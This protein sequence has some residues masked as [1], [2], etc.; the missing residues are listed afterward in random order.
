M[1]VITKICRV[2]GKP[3]VIDEADQAFYEKVG[4]PLPTLCPEER[5]RRRFAHR[6]ERSLYHRKCDLSGKSII[7][8]FAPDSGFTVYENSEWW[9]D[10]W[11][12]KSY[13]RDFDF[14]RPFFDQFDELSKQVPELAMGVW[15]SENSN[16]CNYVGNVKDSYLIFGSVYS[17]ACY[18][19][20]PYYSLNCVDTLVVR[21]C[22]Y[23]YECVD[24]RKLY[25][26][27]YCQDC[28]SSDSL[29][30]CY[31]LQGCSEC[32]GCAGLRNKKFCVFNEQ[33]S[34]EDYKKMKTDLNLCDPKVQKNLR[35][36]LAALKIQIPHRY[37]Q[38][39]QA[40]NASGNYIF[41]SKNAKNCYFT[42]R[43]EDTAYT[44]QVVDLKDCSD[45]NYTEENEL[46][47]E[48]LGSYQN[49]KL[50]FSKFCNKVSEGFYCHSCFTS[51][52]LFGCSGM[53]NASYCILNKQYTKEEYEELVTKIIAHME[54]TG[55]WGE[56]FPISV[57]P[58][59]YN[60]TV[61][62]E[63]FP[64]SCEEVLR[65][66]WRWKEDDED[67][68][69]QG[70]VATV[71]ENIA[72]VS[73]EILKQILTCEVSGKL[74]KLIPQELEFYRKM[75]LPIPRRAPNQR[76]QDRLAMRNPQE[77]WVRQCTQC[78]AEMQTTYAPDRQ[79]KVYCEKCYLSLVY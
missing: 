41:Q 4:V 26:C 45:N 57:S 65:H 71:P 34:E 35:E 40:E 22:Q 18:Y 3:F 75:K 50:L 11:D 58:F 55:E 25:Q 73:D 2:S 48:Y 14:S 28:H 56:F 79:E 68:S 23:C 47:Y 6:N 13:G 29:I 5:R 54:K 64:M 33:L 12:A 24:S 63:Y 78:Q 53:R 38:S 37:M 10:K 61:A 21:E 1:G 49:Q 27:F 7:S 74:Y 16:Y 70:P 9:S 76:H 31:D 77:L 52:H 67:S 51:H 15:N 66:G 32:I 60:E 30:Y 17:E 8:N 20:S 39:R 69:Y 42:D 62:G 43:S 19:G 36:K 46:C 72:E 59:A 44:M